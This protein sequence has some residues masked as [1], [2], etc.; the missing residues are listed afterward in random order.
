MVPAYSHK[1]P[2]VPWYSGYSLP[3]SNFAYRNFTFFVHPFQKCSTIFV[4]ALRESATPVY[5]TI[6]RFGLF[7]FRSPLL[8]ESF[9]YFLFLRVLRCFSSPGSPCQ[10]MYSLDNTCP[11]TGEFPHSDICGS[12]LMC[13][14]PQLFAAC[15]V[16]LRRLVP[17]HPPY[18]LCSLIVFFVNPISDLLDSS[19][20]VI[21][22]HI[23]RIFKLIFGMS[24]IIPVLR[25]PSV[26]RQKTLY[27]TMQLSMCV[28]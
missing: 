7:P 14:S 6:N 15:H 21:Y 12:K 1:I 28:H 3:Y 27:S 2:R 18:A 24:F 13:S 4:C 9:A 11:A 16:L 25:L 23:T 8:G 26:S 22:K 20:I 17:R 19:A 10:A 5:I